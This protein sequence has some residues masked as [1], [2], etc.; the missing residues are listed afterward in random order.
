MQG[1]WY[2]QSSYAYIAPTI[3]YRYRRIARLTNNTS[4]GLIEYYGKR[5]SNYPGGVRGYIHLA[6][7]AG[8]SMSVQHD[9]VGGDGQMTPEVYIDNDRYI[10]LRMVGAAWNSF[11]RWRWIYRDG[12]T[13]YDGSTTQNSQPSNSALVQYGESKRFTWGNVSSITHNYDNFNRVKNLLATNELRADIFR[14]V[15]DANYYIEPAGSSILNNLQINGELDLRGGLDDEA[16]SPI[17]VYGNLEFQDNQTLRFGN[18]SDFQMWWNGADMYFKNYA[19]PNGDIYFLGEDTEGTEHALLYMRTDSSRPYVQLFENGGERLRTTSYGV[20]INDKIFVDAPNNSEW[21][22]LQSASN[23]YARIRMFGRDGDP[24]IEFSDASNS[25]GQ[26]QVWALGADDRDVGSFVIRWG[27][28]TLFPSD[29]TSHGSEYF[30]LKHNG[31]LSLSG[32]EPNSYRLHIGG[33]GYAS[34]DFRA[35]IFYDSNDTGYY[36]NPAGTS[37]ME[38]IDFGE[39]SNDN[40]GQVS[41][42]L[43]DG[44][45]LFRAGT[46]YNHKMWYYDGLAFSTNGSHGHFRFYNETNT[47]RNNSTGGANLVFD[48]DSTNY[49]ATLYGNMYSNIYYDRNN[50]AYYFGSSDGDSRFRNVRTNNIQVENGATLTSVNGNGRIYMGGN[51]HIDSYNGQDIYVNYYSNRRFRVWNGSSAERFRVDTNGIVYAFSELRTPIMYDNNDTTYRIDGNGTSV[52]NQLNVNAIDTTDFNNAAHWSGDIVINGNENTYYPVTWWGGNQDI[53]CEIEIYRG[54]SEQAPWNPIG[55]GVHHGGLTMLMRANFGGWGGSNYDWQFD[56]FRETY[57]TIVADVQRFGNSRGFCFWLRGGGSG[58]ARYHVRI[59]GRS[60]APTISYSTYDPGGNGTGVSPRNDTPQ[61]NINSRNH[62]RGDDIYAEKF[63]DYQD[64]SSYLEPGG[65]SYLNDVRANIFYDRGNTSYYVNPA[66]GNTSTALRIN[67]KIYRD[68]F[69]GGD[70]YN[71]KLLEA[72]DY[73]HWIWNTATNWGIMWAGDNNPYRSYWSSSNPNEIV[74]IGSGNLRAS[75]DLDN[76]NTYFQGELRIDGEFSNSNYARGNLQPGALNIGRTDRNYR[77]DGTS[78]AG[79]INVGILANT[80]DHWEFAIHDS[81]ESVESVF[82]YNSGDNTITM[83]RDIGW[84]TTAIY[85]SNSFRAP[86]FYDSN[87]TTF[88]ADPA[89]RSYFRY[90]Q[91]HSDS[92]RDK[93]R[94]YPSSSYA[95]GMQSGIRFGHLNDWAMTFQFN[96]ENDRGFWWGDDAH[97]TSQG[98]MS[99]TTEGRLTVATSLSVGQGQSTTGPSTQTLY[100]G[101]GSDFA[102]ELDMLSGNQIRLYTSSGNIRGY[103]QSTESNDAH[104]IIATSGGEDISFRDGGLSGDWNQIIRGN[105]QVLVRGRLDSPIF[106]DRDDTGYYLDPNTTGTSLNARGSVIGSNINTSIRYLGTGVSYDTNRTTKVGSGIAL[107]RGYNGGA[108]RPWTYDFAAQFVGSGSGFEF[109][110]DWISS[111]STGLKIRSLRDCCQNWSSWTDVA[112]SGRGFTN[113]VHLRAPIFEDSNNTGYY[114]DPDSTSNSALRMRGGALFGPNPTW[115]R[116]LYVGTNGNVSSEAC[117]ATTNGNLHLDSRS[118]SS[119]YLQ[120]YVGGTTYVNGTIQANRFSDRDNT[121]Y[122]SEHAST[123]YYNDLRSNILYDR[124]NTDYYWHGASTSRSNYHRINNL[125][126]SQERRF[127][128]PNGASSTGNASTTNGAIRIYLPANRRRVNTM[129]RFRVVLY[130]YNTGRSTTWEIGGYNYY[131]GQWYNVFA[132]QLTDAGKTAYTVRWGDDGSRQWVTIGENSSSWSYPQVNITDLQLGHSGYSTNWG[133][134]WIINFGNIPG[135]TN[136]T[137][138]AS[139]VLTT[140]N[141][142]NFRSDASFAAIQATIMRDGNDTNYYVDPASTSRMNQIDLNLLQFNDGFDIYD[143]D[144]NTMTIRSNNSDN[145][146]I[147]FRDSNSTF[148]GRIRWDDDSSPNMRLDTRSDERFVEAVRDSHTY[149]HYNGDWKIRTESWGLRVND[150]L[151]AEGDVIAYYSDMRLKDKVGDIE[152]ALDK[153]GKLNGFYYR[154]N[155]EANFIGYAGNDLQVGLSAQDVESVLPEIVHPAP[156]AE[157]MGYDYKTINYDR[158]VPLLV[159]AINEQKEIVESQK[160]EIEYLKSELSE[161]KELMKQLLNKK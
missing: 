98:A 14:D 97:S 106:Y 136:A 19:H 43:N 126:D 4:I 125:Y 150:D 7:Y 44:A 38:R 9:Q 146:E 78:W 83:G 118:G 103:I 23:G 157:R 31:N 61:S 16:N 54:Y 55:T 52:L 108:N 91:M 158:I 123:S 87:D 36:T 22:D 30:Q 48:I 74:F 120:W 59:K 67:G 58:G 151:R 144:A 25:A 62:R 143:D 75:I 153:V 3:Y 56:D 46:D 34:S 141:A 92:T 42:A 147:N 121:G 11:M 145:G 26:D 47:L 85:A 60:T 112:T 15:N 50:T 49:T 122:Y 6:T 68:G 69:G 105:G 37:R 32:G 127:T 2:S 116:Y 109:S 77:W 133:Q 130:E 149:I 156:L 70:G 139:L 28:S 81:G 12:Q 132:T 65:T 137:R 107:Y 101:G 18:G 111:G 20:E 51:F 35:P 154:N 128:N 1:R 57:T 72:Q 95:I 39:G 93:I 88:Y 161:M 21:I 119:L 155:K 102:G 27:G 99:L 86:I 148:C 41:I 159:N 8:S 40:N 66:A 5:D 53:V 104:L 90:L 135:G 10:W 24:V 71:N 129:H 100:V 73:T 152:N 29:W 160:E 94:V 115:G 33:T 64:T 13:E 114:I 63:Y 124:E 45:L 110:V 79:S 89:S 82:Y 138:T 113:S 117:V 134:D 142:D 96:N 76:G 17:E 131:T 84:G 80:A 140:N